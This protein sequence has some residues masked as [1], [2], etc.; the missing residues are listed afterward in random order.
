MKPDQR[1]H[2][3]LRK[4][5]AILGVLA[6]IGAEA[7]QWCPP[8]ARFVYSTYYYLWDGYIEWQY[9]G[10]TLMSD[11]RQAKILRGES[12][13]YWPG[14][15]S[16]ITAGRGQWFTYSE[17]DVIYLMD[18]NNQWDTLFNFQLAIGERWNLPHMMQFDSTYCDTNSYAIVLDTGI[19]NINGQSLRWQ[20]VAFTYRSRI[21]LSAFTDTVFERIGTL[22]SYLLPTVNCWQEGGL[23]ELRCYS[24]DAFPEFKS[25]WT[26]DKSCYH[27]FSAL[28]EKQETLRIYPNPTNDYLQLNIDQELTYQIL[29]MQGVCVQKGA[30]RGRID[31]LNLPPG[32]YI[33]LLEGEVIRFVKSR[34][35]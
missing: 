32:I 7:Q 13:Y 4:W 24:D 23:G 26:S 22:S 28:D 34:A 15:D 14:A 10:D 20:Y 18:V 33:L 6:A 27:L 3:K 9:S 1:L 11:G 12:S 17:N 8:G 29:S 31:V 16:I 25:G 19:R 2:L 30:S 35:Y 21:P 5:F